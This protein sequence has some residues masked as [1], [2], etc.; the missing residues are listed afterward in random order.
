M[1]KFV[2]KRDVRRFSWIQVSVIPA[3]SDLG[4][5]HHIYNTPIVLTYLGNLQKHSIL[6]AHVR[7]TGRY[8]YCII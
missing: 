8:R 5:E 6:L 3:D 1:G 2:E 4:L 7:H